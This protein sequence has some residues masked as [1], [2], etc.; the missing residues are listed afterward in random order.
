MTDRISSRT[1]VLLLIFVVL[2]IY[3]PAIF[4][5]INSVD[6]PRTVTFLLNLDSFNLRE[7]FAPG[8]VYFRPLLLLSFLADSYL[9]GLQASFMHLENVLFH[10]VNVLLLFAVA[11][12]AAVANAVDSVLAPL[13]VALLFAVHPINTES[14]NWI[15]GRTDPL[16]CMFILL[17]AFFL[18]KPGGLSALTPWSSLFAALSLLA[19]CLAKETAIFFLPA[20]FIVPFFR[21][22]RERLSLKETALRNWPHLLIMVATGVLFLAYRRLGSVN[23]DAGLSCVATRVAGSESSGLSHSA[24]LVFKAAGFYLKKIFLPL[25]LNFCIMHV[26]NLYLWVG[27]LVLLLTLWLLTRRTLVAFFFLCA[28]SVSCSALMIPLLNATWTPLAERYL[29][30]PSAFFALGCVFGVERWQLQDR[31]KVVVTV[32]FAFILA[33]AVYTTSARTLLWQDNLALFQDTIKKSPEFVPAQ[34]EIAVAYG[35]L[36]QVGKANQIL[37]SMVLPESLLNRQ[38]G[39]LAKSQVRLREG[40]LDAA[41]AILENA[42]KTD[43]GREEVEFSRRLLALYELKVAQGKARGSEFYPQSV[44]LLTRTYQLTHDPFYLYRLGS[45]HMQQKKYKEASDNFRLAAERAPANAY[46][47]EPA[48]KLARKLADRTSP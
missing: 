37:S 18:L 21:Q 41:Q 15:S 27:G 9:W 32:A 19:G 38:Y 24:F 3:Y 8:G 28:L 46:Y 35:A 14:V 2:G 17:S 40:N 1:C 31:A 29:Y 10:L 11:R 20:A 39:V 22:D 4:A 7:I 36:G 5:P 25:P 30:I 26:S 6:D 47:R 12:R 34:N 23:N 42:L 48:L 16:A 33:A 43:P 13:A 44:H 45:L